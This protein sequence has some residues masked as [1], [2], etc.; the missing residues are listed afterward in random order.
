[1]L[2][3]LPVLVPVGTSSE[4]ARPV[5]TVNIQ[6]GQRQILMDKT[7]GCCGEGSFIAAVIAIDWVA[8]RCIK[9]AAGRRAAAPWASEAWQPS[10]SWRDLMGSMYSQ[11]TV[12]CGQEMGRREPCS[13]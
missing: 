10:C 7:V 6:E 4:Q 1:V 9:S 5:K 12:R 11:A 3:L 8:G 13:P 2:V